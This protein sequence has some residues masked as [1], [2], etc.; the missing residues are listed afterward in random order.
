MYLFFYLII[1]KKFESNL[2]KSNQ[3]LKVKP[4]SHLW[5]CILAKDWRVQPPS[6]WTDWPHHSWRACAGSYADPSSPW[7]RSGYRRMNPKTMENG[8]LRSRKSPSF[9]VILKLLDLGALATL[10]SNNM[11][12]LNLELKVRPAVWPAIRNIYINKCLVFLYRLADESWVT[13]VK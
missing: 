9:V 8:D 12:S 4:L 3:N 10:L 13:S 6:Y 11:E 1:K 2:I 7:S 5:N